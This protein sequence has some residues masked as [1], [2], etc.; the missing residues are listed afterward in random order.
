M[1]MKLQL[2]SI[3]V[4]LLAVKAAVDLKNQ[5]AVHVWFICTSASC[6]F[7]PTSNVHKQLG[8]DSHAE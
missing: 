5:A 7:D 8:P 3:T 6:N 4:C 2:S 1:S